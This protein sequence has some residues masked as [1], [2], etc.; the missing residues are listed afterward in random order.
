[1][2]EV[3][4]IG[5]GLQKWGELWEKSLRQIYVEAA[6]NAIKDAGVDHIDSM[7]IGSMSGGLFAC[8]AA[9]T[10]PRYFGRKYLGAISG[11]SM[12]TFVFASAIGPALFGFSESLF[13]SYDK[14]IWLSAVGPVI[15]FLGSFAVKKHQ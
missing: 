12:A 7:Y 4:I 5:V 15:V 1:M 10:W 3:A 14:A 9:V 11:L 13:A 6:S 8:L 2:R